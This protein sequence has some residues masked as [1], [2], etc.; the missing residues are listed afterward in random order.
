M[1]SVATQTVALL[2]ELVKIESIN[3]SL[4]PKGSGEK[5]VADFLGGFCRER[6][7]PYEFQEVK[8]GRSNFLTWV[9]GQDADKRIVFVAHMDTVPIDR[10]ESDPFSG[11]QREGR[12]YGRGSCDTKGSLAAMLIALGTIGERQPK[13]T[14]VVA[15]SIDEEFRK[16]GARA[17]GLSGVSY[18]AAVVGEPTDLELVV[19]HKGSV[20]WQV[21][22][23]GVPAHTSKPH[24][25]VN[26]ITGMA[27]IVL[28]LDELN[29]EL[30]LR[31]HPLVGSPTLTVSLIEGGIELTTV[32]PVCRIWIDRRLIPGERPQQAIQEV[33]NILESFRQG[34]D[35]INVRS[36]LPALEDPAPDSAESSKI[37]AV[38]AEACADVAGTGKYIGVPY[39]TDASQLSLAGIPCVVIGPGSIDQAHTNNEFVEIDQ[40]VKAVE[41]YQKVMLNY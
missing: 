4:S 11:E 39:G 32:P 24:L 10:W 3:P 14:V 26:A 31:T 13:S 28:A 30:A 9:P 12:I 2:Q 17:I 7:L 15:A 34:E 40:L 1:S 41:I 6:N 33:E 18:D 8:D 22:V 19:A 29:Q 36:L 20:R 37:A 5:K 25:G 38:A 16:I 27:K 23:E 35:N 21:E